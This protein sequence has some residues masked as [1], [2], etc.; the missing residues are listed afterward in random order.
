MK[1]HFTIFLA[2]IVLFT[3]MY[4]PKMSTGAVNNQDLVNV[5]VV[6]EYYSVIMCGDKMFE[7]YGL[8]ITNKMCTSDQY[9]KENWVTGASY[10]IRDKYGACCTLNGECGKFIANLSMA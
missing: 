6:K 10:Q 4:A 7:S 8:P 9:C 2:I 3:L 1:T 5:L